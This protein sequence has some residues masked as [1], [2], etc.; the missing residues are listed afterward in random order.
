MSCFN[1]FLSGEE[2]MHGN[3]KSAFQI[4]L[5][6]F[7]LIAL[8]L[9]GCSVL[10][11]SLKEDI[12]VAATKDVCR[13]FGAAKFS[14]SSFNV[15]TK[16]DA[17]AI[18]RSL[19]SPVGTVF[20]AARDTPSPPPAQISVPAQMAINVLGS[21]THR[22]IYATISA[23][24]TE[25]PV[26]TSG[27][28]GAGRRDATSSGGNT[29]GDLTISRNE[30]LEYSKMIEKVAMVDGWQELATV[31]N[32][33]S[34]T[35]FGGSQ[36][37]DELVDSVS[38]E[39]SF[40]G[41]YMSAYFRN[42]KF[43]SVSLE[44]AKIENTLRGKLKAEAS[45]SLGLS[46]PDCP[47]KRPD[48]DKQPPKDEQGLLLHLACQIEDKVSSLIGKACKKTDDKESPKDACYLLSRIADAGFVSRGGASFAFPTINVSVNPLADKKVTATKIDT[49]QIAQDLVRVAV[50]ATGDSITSVPAV[51][52]STACEQ[53]L[54]SCFDEERFNVS[55]DRF[56]RVNDYADR[57][58]AAVSAI[59]GKLVRGGSWIALNNEAL[60]KS[61]ETFI[62]VTVRKVTETATWTY[63][64]SRACSPVLSTQ[65][66]AGPGISTGTAIRQLTISV[67]R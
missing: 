24:L 55:A 6:T 1:D 52:G 42:G 56:N 36:I 22:K 26:P 39:A 10:S 47:Q 23:S 27:V 45:E 50:E 41:S 13:P 15:R 29:L 35:L 53:G 21:E 18:E 34:K 57:A 61:L 66:G 58:E 5:G 63:L 48:F 16:A 14:E 40:L 62:S 59:I 11:T 25:S 38:R 20:G 65:F 46:I 12:P 28:F 37:R 19:L 43:F 7:V 8:T 60:A 4:E 9:S 30:F 33:R 44:R 49:D 54:L 64:S 67:D 17:Q 3:R 2:F 32:A 31:A 51:K